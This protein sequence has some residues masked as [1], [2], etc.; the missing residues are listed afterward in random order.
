MLIQQVD[1]STAF[2]GLRYSKPFLAAV[3][4]IPSSS[5]YNVFLRY[6]VLGL[7]ATTSGLLL[8]TRSKLR[9]GFNHNRINDIRDLLR[10]RLTELSFPLIVA[11]YLL[12]SANLL[13]VLFILGGER[14][15]VGG[16]TSDWYRIFGR[17]SIALHIVL[18]LLVF[19]WEKM[20]RRD[21]YILFTP[22]FLAVVMNTLEG[23][24][25]Y[26]LETGLLLLLCSALKYGNYV[27]KG[28]WFRLTFIMAI[29]S[30]IAYPLATVM[31]YVTRFGR[32]LRGVT[33][34]PEIGALLGGLVD[35]YGTASSAVL[36]VFTSALS[37]LTSFQ[38]G[39]LIMNDMNINPIG[40]LLSVSNIVKR[41]GNNLWIGEPFPGVMSPQY[42]FDH[43]YFDRMIGF[44]A[45]N[46]GIWEQFYLISGYWSGLFWV[47]V[48]MLGVGVL[49][50]ALLF[51]KSSFKTF[52]ITTF[53]YYLWIMFM[54]FDVSYGL[55]SLLIELIVFNV[56][57]GV[58]IVGSIATG[59]WRTRHPLGSVI[60]PAGKSA[61]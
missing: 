6:S 41:V 38:T 50:K 48:L 17:T 53:I 8:G 20:S 34:A 14:E 4:W 26:F 22:I 32:G 40:D 7:I 11:W 33:E 10:D 23:T 35:L 3:Y 12:L 54:N 13:Y 30:L 39:L 52:Y 5:D 16:G 55:S 44:N 9:F 37:A 56:M 27:I 19:N 18:A 61:A 29:V 59:K 58:L 51:S 21:K 1:V 60:R 28:K 2:E 25:S 49:W 46:W 15:I 42:L 31:R 45:H 36:A 57:I 24:R 47:F 43:I